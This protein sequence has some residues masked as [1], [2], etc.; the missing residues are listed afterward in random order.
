VYSRGSRPARYREG[1]HLGDTKA[2]NVHCRSVVNSSGS[3]KQFHCGRRPLTTVVGRET[4]EAA[5]ERSFVNSSSSSK[6]FH[7]G[8]R[9]LTTV[10]GRE[11]DEAAIEHGS[12]YVFCTCSSSIF[13]GC[14]WFIVRCRPVLITPDGSYRS[15][16]ETPQLR[17]IEALH[18]EAAGALGVRRG[19]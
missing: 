3:S 2:N 10:V 1:G 9:P 13:Y 11:T 17:G 19:S 15:R 4:D 8:R 5:D 16:G 6:Q 12:S 18:R 7:C 14:C